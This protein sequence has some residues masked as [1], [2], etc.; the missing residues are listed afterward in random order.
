MSQPIR[1]VHINT[2]L[3]WR[4]GEQQTLSLVE[5]LARRGHPAVLVASPRSE[6]FRRARTAGIEAVGIH[7][8]NE[9]DPRAF[10]K[11]AALLRRNRPAI[12]HL[13]TSHGH[14]LGLLAC[15][16]APPMKKVVSRRVDFSIYRNSFLGLNGLKYRHG[17]DRYITVSRAVAD[18]LVRD[19]V[20]RE[21]VSVVHSGV[22]PSRFASVRRGDGARLEA[23]RLRRELDLPE[24]LPLIT[25]VGALADHKGHRFLIEAA[26]AVLRRVDAAFVI[27]GVGPR[28]RALQR[29]IRR[30]GVATRVRLAGF[31]EDIGEILTASTVFAFPSIEEGLGTSILDAL[32]LDRPVVAASSGG[33]PEIIEDRRHGLLVP[34]GDA[35]ALAGAIAEML[36]QPSMAKELARRGKD[37][38]LAE[39]SADG[40]VEGTIEVYREV[41]KS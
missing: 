12:L 28:R 32:I 21:R 7:A 6:I 30:M 25:S 29:I 38:V 33:I 17:I 22:N 26:P 5:G 10:L 4:G 11:I 34:P 40:M 24:G 1:S 27:V 15:A 13:H 36:E 19:G 37:R 20:A 41:L 9:V 8:Y 18:L 23:S 3:T 16:F 39:F 14:L 35:D 31:R 2:E